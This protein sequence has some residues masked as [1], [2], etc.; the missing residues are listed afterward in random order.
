MITQTKMLKK[1]LWELVV[2]IRRQ[3]LKLPFADLSDAKIIEKIW[4]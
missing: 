4:K 2:K 1:Q 3:I